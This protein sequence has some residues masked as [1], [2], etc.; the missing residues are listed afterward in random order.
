MTIL[1][2]YVTSVPWPNPSRVYSQKKY[3]WS[4]PGP[5]PPLP[6]EVGEATGTGA[7]NVLISHNLLSEASTKAFELQSKAYDK[8]WGTALERAS[9]GIS[10]LESRKSLMMIKQRV[11]QIT[12]A[13]KSLR[14]LDWKGVNRALGVSTSYR[15][16]IF[17][18]KPRGGVKDTTKVNLE[19]TWLEYT[20]GWV[21]LYQDIFSACKVLGQDF[22]AFRHKVRVRDVFYHIHPWDGG[23]SW[24]ATGQLVYY[25][26]ANIRIK[27]PNL[28]LANQLGLLNPAYVL[29]DKVAFSFVV[30]WIVPVGKFL[31]SLTNTIGLEV[32]NAYHGWGVKLGGFSRHITLP[33]TISRV[34][35]KG[36][37]RFLGTISTPSL[38]SRVR[39]P[40]L[41][42]WLAVTSLSLL[43]QQFR[44]VK[45]YSYS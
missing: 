30:D 5:R 2:P 27:N 29:W 22:T 12:L 26:G 15:P 41:D 6:Y 32:S 4:G 3:K 34:S 7:W 13:V 37:G 8:F 1:G 18:G 14:R 16:R 19:K 36:G 24:S 40:K 17:R 21:P 11:D 42:P 10:L 31:R 25:F 33:D 38:L 44:A 43:S 28:L 45:T 23:A 35:G 9:L 20:F 39:I